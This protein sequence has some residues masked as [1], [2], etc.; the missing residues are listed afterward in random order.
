[1]K[2][3]DENSMT[4]MLYYFR[5]K[6]IGREVK[7]IHT[8]S[9]IVPVYNGQDRLAFFFDSILNQTY[10]ALEI[11]CVN[12]GSTDDSAQIIEEYRRKDSRIKVIE[13]ENAGAGAARNAGLAEATGEYCSFLDCDDVFEPDMYERMYE[14]I[15]AT[16]SDICICDAN[17]INVLTGRER[18]RKNFIDWSRA[19]KKKVFSYRDIPDRIFNIFS[20]VPWNKLYRTALIREK[21]LLF[22]NTQN[23]NDVCFVYTSLVLANR[24]TLI[25]DILVHK[26]IINDSI[27]RSAAKKWKDPIR[28]YTKLRKDLIAEGKFEAVE[29]SFTNKAIDTMTWN[30]SLLADDSFVELYNILK[31]G[32]L[33]SL[34]V[35]EQEKDDYYYNARYN[36]RIKMIRHDPPEYYRLIELEKCRL[37]RA[38]LTPNGRLC[39]TIDCPKS[40]DGSWKGVAVEYRQIWADKIG[41]T[42]IVHHFPARIKSDASGVTLS[43]SIPLKDIDLKETDWRV[44]CV[45]ERNDARTLIYIRF[46]TSVMKLIRLFFT[47]NYFFKRGMIVYFYSAKGLFQL[48][49]RK[50]EH[51]DGALFRFKEM[52]AVGLSFLFR[53][54]M[55]RR[56]IM[57]IHEKK[58]Y[59]AADNGF[60][61]FRYCMENAA[62]QNLKREIYYIIDKRSPH[63]GRLR[64]WDDRVIHYLSLRH[65]F[66][67]LVCSVIVSSESKTHDYIRYISASI[68]KPLIQKKDH[69]YLKHGVFAIKRVA[70]A[71]FWGRKSVLMTAVSENE[72][73][74]IRKYLRYERSRVAVTGSARFDYL[75]D[76]SD[77]RKEI[78][79]MPTIRIQLFYSGEEDFK[80]SDYYRVYSSLL[81]SEKL[82]FILKKYGYTL[83]FYMHPSFRQFEHL[84][85]SDNDS[86]KIMYDDNAPIGDLLA[87]C[88]MLITDYSSVAWD[89]LYMNKPIL[90]FQFDTDLFLRTSGSYMDLYKDLPGDRCETEEDL[91]VLIGEY[92]ANGLQIPARYAKIR[93]SFFTY[94]DRGNCRRIAE[95]INRRGL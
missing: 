95:E 62:D 60:A 9:V 17:A 18:T 35:F 48:V 69:V 49:V 71:P 12:D 1:M 46:E 65:M 87:R 85:K 75:S 89:V 16:D 7:M 26:S 47:R 22:Q 82:L 53:R 23:T 52:V 20:P 57:L 68:L 63:Y 2:I 66:Y 67:I 19:P 34:G 36:Q 10:R 37:R 86:V 31:N 70:P 29:R 43:A 5:K 6:A 25:D 88:G 90:F 64:Q 50:R 42:P 72:A 24:I 38:R 30:L 61:F 94:T 44:A 13:Q 27:S 3:S 59:R 14:R 28:A 51:Y 93:E 81:Q 21:G 76:Q 58:C 78:L 54:A 11:I 39:M 15:I 73:N 80:N 74:I 83:N 79:L 41:H 40:A 77:D 56:K 45:L 33:D 84:F 55:K 8:I 4:N 91:L 32:G 92:A